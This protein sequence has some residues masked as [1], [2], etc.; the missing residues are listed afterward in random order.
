MS[1][2]V[3]IVFT[4]SGRRGEVERGTAVLDAARKLGVDLDSV[5]GGRGLCGRCQV[6]CSA[7][8]FPKF[9]FTSNHEHL[10]EFSTLEVRYHE[11]LK[12]LAPGRRLGCQARLE[13]DLV[14]DVPKDSQVH[15]QV[16]RKEADT[17]DIDIDPIYH[18]YAVRVPEPDMD[19]PKGDLDRLLEVLR[20]EWQL[21]IV[22]Y[23]P[24]LLVT[25][26]HVLRE[27]DWF[28][29]VAVRNRQELI[30]VWP[31]FHDRLYGIAFDVGSTT[32]AANLCDLAS[33]DVIASASSMNPQIR[34]GEDL[35]SRVSYVML[36]P[37]D[38]GELTRVIRLA[39]SE[40][41]DELTAP[42]GVAG[43]EIVDLVFVANP[44]MHHILLGIS[45]VELGGAPFALTVSDA[46]NMK[47][48]GLGL[49]GVN[50]AA[51][52]YVLPCIAGH[53]GAD[54]AGM[55]LSEAPQNHEAVT[56][57]VDVGTN[58]EIVLGNKHRLLACSSPTGPAFE[59]AQISCGQRAAAGAVERVRIDPDSLL[60]RFKVIGSDI[61]SDHADFDHKVTG[62]CGSGIIEVI[63]EMYL[64]GIITSEGIINGGLVDRC[65]G[66]VPEDRTFSYVLHDGE[67]EVRVTQNDVRQ[68]QLAKAALYAGTKLLMQHLGVSR[69][70][71]IRLAG[72]FGSQIDVT[73]AMAIGLIPDCQLAEVS[74]AGN[75]A[76]TGARIALLNSAARQEIENVVRQ[77][78][79]VETATEAD[80][81]EFFVSAM[82]FPHGSDS[83]DALFS[84]FR[85]PE[86][87]ADDA[88][89]GGGRRRNRR[90]V[91]VVEPS[92]G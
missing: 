43:A 87:T 3:Q 30:A 53:V 57:L 73:R 36:H 12:P 46:V 10:S 27:G 31:G 13:G 35:M 70:D 56:L 49:T 37:D 2:T 52:V 62:I 41:V 4:P 85:K 64:A 47:A 22:D 44:V 66:I 76:G 54:A 88:P 83:F 6:T 80:F 67:I 26:Q 91:Q 42:N 50:P 86:P 1:D 89:S 55:V 58:A 21:D 5:C 7:G 29:T 63:A 78:E 65:P 24:H 38:A 19:N 17:R 23:E 15:Q 45:P 92:G 61:W 74:S 14:I 25:L 20:Q 11:K 39:L 40:L 16:V 18:L 33:G 72:A 79:K 68:I 34:F 48:D 75:A 82:S 90:R 71:R 8:E 9:G 59:G 32:V 51:S 84:H 81:Q 69:V 60:P 28:V 77:I